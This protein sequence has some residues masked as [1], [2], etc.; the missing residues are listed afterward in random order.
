MIPNPDS[1]RFRRIEAGFERLAPRVE[2]PRH[3]HFDPYVSMVL[4]GGY[5]QAG[6]FGRARLEPG[7]VLV[8]PVLDRHESRQPGGRGV[9]LLRLPWTLEPG[10]LGGRYRPRNI[11]LVIRVARRDAF[12]ASHLLA[13]MLRDQQPD[14]A[15]EIDWPDQLAA[16]LRCDQGLTI[17]EWARRR[18]L[19]RE[20]MSRG[21][22]R[23][24][25][26]TPRS[27]AAELRAREAWI[28]TVFR[29]GKLSDIAADL[30]FAD[31]AHM[32]R[33]VGGLTGA[34]PETWRRRFRALRPGQ[35]ESRDPKARPALR[36][37]GRRDASR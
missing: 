5:D 34:P 2:L 6:Y 19:A 31:Q 12:E 23:T 21:F 13:E 25:G 15:A 36:T 14:P 27:F 26:V 4:D 10:G 3:A 1:E 17:G 35:T 24:F 8:Q 11:D 29:P 18:G 32:T 9:H 37:T 30:A 7:D 22:L 20:T 28:H 16:A 33:A